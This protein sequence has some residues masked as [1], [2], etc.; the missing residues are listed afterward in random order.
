MINNC[1]LLFVPAWWPCSFF[2]E[3]QALYRPDFVV[4]RLYGSCNFWSRRN[5]YRS[6]ILGNSKADIQSSVDGNSAFVEINCLRISEKS[7]DRLSIISDKI[8]GLVIDMMCGKKP[9]AIY[10]QSISDIAVFVVNWAKRNRIPIVLAEHVLYIRRQLNFFSSQKESLYSISDMVF[11][12]SNS[13]YRNLLTHGFRLNKVSV[14]GN[15]VNDIGVP[16]KWELNKNGRIIFVAGHT[17]DKDI[18]TLFRVSERL[19][20]T[21]IKIDVFGLSGDEAYDDC[22]TL[23]K[24]ID[25]HHLCNTIVFLGMVNHHELLKRYSDYSLLLSTS[26][27]ETFGLSIA[28]A[29]AHG[30]PVVC[31]NSGGVTDFVNENNGIIVPIR[32]VDAIVNAIH[33]VFNR[34]YDYHRMSDELLDQFGEKQYRSRASLCTI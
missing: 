26:I 24:W 30:T 14:I 10:I 9:G 31:T 11:C 15:Y 34:T 2:E 6:L 7:R 27:S 20:D 25:E 16:L 23:Q 21:G 13:V 18:N 5:Y 12:V 22:I 33:A 17:A 29:I 4:Y 32:D 8:G 28:E 3:Q 1:N 19:K